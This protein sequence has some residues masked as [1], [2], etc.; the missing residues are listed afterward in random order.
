MAPATPVAA[1]AVSSLGEQ[2]ARLTRRL[3]PRLARGEVAFF[4]GAGIHLG[5]LPSARDFYA[6]LSK[7]Y[8]FSEEDAQRAEIA[9]YLIDHEGK[10]Q[11]WAAARHKLTT[12]NTMPSVVCQFVADLPALLRRR[13]ST[14]TADQWLLTTNYDV[15]L[16]ETLAK[17]GERFHLLAHQVDGEHEGRFAHRNLSGSIRIIERPDNVRRLGE[18]ANVIVKLDGGISWDPNIP[19]TVAIS[20]LDFGISSGRL[21]T[22]LPDVVR[23]V[24]RTRALLILGSSM[25]DAHIQRLVRWSAG[26]AR[27][28]KTWAVM[29]PV[30]PTAKQYWTA[31]GVEI[32][33]CDLADFVGELRHQLEVAAVGPW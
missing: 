26:N 13:G 15:V 5:V 33:D 1:P 20:P 2:G 24:L 14:E 25:R 3:A 19:E 16:E 21:L 17:R 18:P 30:S 11:A 10:R 29:K 28:V 7:E 8:G 27:A 6:A 32:I 22:A 31:A 4:L 9:Q 23:Q 12:A